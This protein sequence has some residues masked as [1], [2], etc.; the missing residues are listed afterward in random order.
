M[1]DTDT[2][3]AITTTSEFDL[4]SCLNRLRFEPALETEFR[5]DYERR[6]LGSRLSLVLISILAVAATP[7]YDW[8]FLFPPPGFVPSSRLLQFG[9]EIP[10]LLI[11]LACCLPRLRRFLPG[12]IIFGA[13][14]TSGG[15]FAQRVIGADFNYVVPFDFAAITIAG[16]YTLGRL[17]FQLFFPW[18]LL[19]VMLVSA[20]EID[21]FGADSESFYNCLSLAILFAMLSTGG[22]LLERTAR[23]NWF[24]RRQLAMLALHD[25]LTGLPNRRHFDNT[26]VQMLRAAARERGNVALM[27]LDID[28]FKS[29][30]DRYGHPAGDAC[31][32]HIGQWLAKRMRRPHD[33]AARIGGEEFVAIW[34][35]ANPQDARRLA[36]SL[37]A[38]IAEL[39]IAHEIRGP[40]GVVTASGGFVEVLAPHPVEAAHDIAK[41][42]MRRADDLLYKAKGAGRDRLFFE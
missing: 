29:Y 5:K 18:A 2:S 39:G 13:L 34:S 24:R 25:P 30:N 35:N 21:T 10:S 16:V 8:W 33:F 14:A 42:M 22:Y 6:S 20:A 17:R 38:G 41:L 32:R 11:G 7:L 23:E 3:T 40:T 26:L 15:L 19:I 27:V 31:L 36:E 9:I 12:A 28:D 37:R 1:P 4:R